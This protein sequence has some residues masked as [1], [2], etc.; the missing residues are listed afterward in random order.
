M[1]WRNFCFIS[2]F[3]KMWT[4]SKSKDFNHI[5][6]LWPIPTPECSGIEFPGNTVC[7]LWGWYIG[8]GMFY[9][10]HHASASI[11]PLLGVNV[12]TQDIILGN[13]KDKIDSRQCIKATLWAKSSGAEDF[14]NQNSRL[15]VYSTLRVQ[16]SSILSV[17]CEHVR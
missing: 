15:K 10:F 11:M 3:H 4:L 12:A 6:H 14:T 5:R 7:Q 13:Y 9:S 17:N 1:I 8:R 2:T 16:L